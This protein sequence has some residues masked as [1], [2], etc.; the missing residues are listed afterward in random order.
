MKNIIFVCTGNV[1][2]SMTAEKCFKDYL[3][4]NKISDI[5]V[6]SA[7][8]GVIVQEIFPAVR[9]RLSFYGIKANH[10]YK[11]LSKNLIKANSLVVAMNFN[12]QIFIKEQFGIDAPLFNQVAFNKNIG[13]LDFE[14]HDSTIT[15]IY[16]IGRA[17]EF[18]AYAYKIVD[19]IYDSM[20][21]FTKNINK[22]LQT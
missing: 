3:Y 2:R 4:K 5:T 12:H 15:D 17:E 9:D 20:P 18:Q 7:G 16:D 10:Q 11:A 19:Y 8:I 1:F 6:D 13:I 22:W 14:E 21:S